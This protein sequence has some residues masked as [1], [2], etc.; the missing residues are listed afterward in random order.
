MSDMTE[1]T[2][3]QKQSRRNLYISLV[4]GLCLLFVVDQGM[5]DWEL[6]TLVSHVESSESYIN[7]FKADL[8]NVESDPNTSAMK[9]D[10]AAADLAG[11]SKGAVATAQTELE[12]TFVLPWHSSI[13]VAKKSYL[14]HNKAWITSMEHIAITGDGAIQSD[15]DI[16]QINQTWTDSVTAIK[17][18]RPLLDVTNVT[19]RLAIIEKQ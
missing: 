9:K 2:A 13:V 8:Y 16:A 17:S 14:L 15:D 4:S 18:A 7:T 6:H 3:E 19:K 12:S 11:K 5:R 10:F 1:M